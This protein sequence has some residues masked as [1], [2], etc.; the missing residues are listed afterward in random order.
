[1][2]TVPFG[3]SS[4]G[5]D[6]SPHQPPR[7]WVFPLVLLYTKIDFSDRAF[8]GN[9][10]KCPDFST[11]IGG[12]NVQIHWA[13][14]TGMARTAGMPHRS[15]HRPRLR[16]QS[17]QSG[18]DCP[19]CKSSS[20]PYI[21]VP[22]HTARSFNSSCHAAASARKSAYWRL[23]STR[24]W[25]RRV[26]SFCSSGYFCMFMPVTVQGTFVSNESGL[27]PSTR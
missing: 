20:N 6:C 13:H 11:G 19:S 8:K 27:G 24:S 26:C 9:H 18:A 3:V 21:S 12:E 22:S 16:F 2:P 25:S 17:S 10:L 1:M 4:T 7:K 23:A 5:R 15:L 14:E